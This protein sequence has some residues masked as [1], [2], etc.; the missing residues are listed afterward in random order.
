[1]SDVMKAAEVV[2]QQKRKQKQL[3]EFYN[4]CKTVE[5]R[6]GFVIA[7][8]D[9]TA[10]FADFGKAYDAGHR[11]IKITKREEANDQEAR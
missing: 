7:L 4:S 10:R 11:G 8:R 6:I 1:M 5:E 9:I 2:R 3:V